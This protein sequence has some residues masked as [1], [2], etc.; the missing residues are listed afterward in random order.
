MSAARKVIQ[1]PIPAPSVPAAPRFCQ[2]P[3]CTARLKR[4]AK[5]YCSRRCM[6]MATASVL[7][8]MASGCTTRLTPAQIR[9]KRRFCCRACY[10]AHRWEH[11]LKKRVTEQGLNYGTVLAAKA[12]R[13]VTE[14]D[15]AIRVYSPRRCA[16]CERAVGVVGFNRLCATCK[17]SGLRWCGTGRHVVALA[18][19][20]PN[21]HACANHVRMRSARDKLAARGVPIDPPADFDPVPV[22]AA[23]LGYSPGRVRSAVRSGWLPLSDVWQRCPE[24]QIFIR[25]KDV[26]PSWRK[27]A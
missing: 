16:S 6:R 8:C 11:S 24:G 19:Y 5:Y 3:G 27:R 26:Y 10:V 12:E 23:K 21:N 14:M 25:R 9:A 2:L 13:R 1:G 7:I 18:D 22:I 4:E 17:A 15:D 20:R